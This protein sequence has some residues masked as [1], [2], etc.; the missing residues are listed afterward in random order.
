MQVSIGITPEEIFEEADWALLIG[1]KPRG[2]GMER[3]DLLEMNG[4]IF[5]DQVCADDHTRTAKGALG[6]FCN[7]R[8][9]HRRLWNGVDEM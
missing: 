4:R 7:Q 1:A 5:V 6:R 3:A 2:P 8:R 9:C